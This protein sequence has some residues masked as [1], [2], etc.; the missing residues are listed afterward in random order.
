MN[1]IESSICFSN[2]SCFA[3]DTRI[4]KSISQAEDQHLLQEDLNQVMRWTERNNMALH[5]DKFIY[6]NFHSSKLRPLLEFP[7]QSQFLEYSTSD[8]NSLLPTDVTKDLGIHISSDLSWNPHVM[9]LV[10]KA[11][12]KTGWSLSVF[13]DRSP[14]VMKTL[15]KSVVRSNL[16]YACPLWS[17]LSIGDAMSLEAVQQRFTSR[18]HFN[19]VT[20]LNYWERLYQSFIAPIK[21]QGLFSFFVE[22]LV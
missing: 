22:C 3:D 19:S 5:E 12:S 18:I 15:Y 17:S 21:K 9:Q 8:S 20:Q 16:E 13:H 2:I 1:D 11:N 7:F 6:L 4:S 10:K 14:H